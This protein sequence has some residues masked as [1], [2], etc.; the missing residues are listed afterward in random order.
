MVHS[1][2]ETLLSAG[3]NMSYQ[4]IKTQGC[5]HAAGSLMGTRDLAN[6]TVT[7]PTECNKDRAPPAAPVKGEEAHRTRRL[8]RFPGTLKY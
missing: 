7:P 6:A 3:E 2:N 1:D 4:I 8:A 5:T